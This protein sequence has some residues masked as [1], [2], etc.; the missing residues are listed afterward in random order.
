MTSLMTVIESLV[1]CGDER[2]LEVLADIRK[3]WVVL[4]FLRFLSPFAGFKA[5]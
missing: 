3:L 4:V 2:K 5:L 1:E